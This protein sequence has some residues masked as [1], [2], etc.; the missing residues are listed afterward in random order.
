VADWVL[1]VDLDQFI[2]AVEVLRRP[3]LRG[4][5]VVVGGDGDPTKR[6]V[7]STASYEARAYGVHSGLP[8]RTALKRCAAA[9]FLP[10]DSE[11]YQAASALVMAALRDGDAIVEVAGWDEA[12]LAVRSDDPEAVAREV[13]RRVLEAT[14]LACTVGIGHNKLQAKMATGYGKPAGVFRITTEGWLDLLG[15]KPT[16]AL[17]GIGGGLGKRLAALGITTVSELAVVDPAA[18]VPAFGPRTGPWLAG[19]GR[20]QFDSPVDDTPREP[21]SRSRETTF[22]VDLAE[23]PDVRAELASLTRGLVNDIAASGLAVGRVYVKV[24]FVPFTTLIRSKKLAGPTRDPDEVAEVALQVL[25]GVGKR[26]AVRLL[27]I[28]A[29]FASDVTPG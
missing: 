27:G 2:A 23:W 20:G 21:V 14:R 22:Q 28:R 3:E 5:P 25:E 9:V 4:Q 15:D 8:M 16:Q 19:L 10:V 26:K 29:E 17:W 6:G 1:H 13:Q 7:V 12:F 18:L 11:T 24:R